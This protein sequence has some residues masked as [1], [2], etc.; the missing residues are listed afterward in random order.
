MADT[1]YGTTAQVQA[2]L[3]NDPAFSATRVQE[4]LNEVA[5]E[6]DSVLLGAGYTTVPLVGVKD[7]LLVR[8]F[9]VPFAA[10]RAYR[11]WYQNDDAPEH[12]ESW[13]SRWTAFLDR[14]MNG[15]TRLPDQQVAAGGLR[16]GSIILWPK[17]SK[18]SGY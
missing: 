10:V 17:P 5:E 3:H 11:E 2:V 15:Q 12:I 8:G 4:I 7:L 6:L 13:E 16:T 9:V 1:A 14:I 18:R